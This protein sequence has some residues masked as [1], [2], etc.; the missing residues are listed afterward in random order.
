MFPAVVFLLSLLCEELSV[1][2]IP[3]EVLH[4]GVAHHRRHVDVNHGVQ[5]LGLIAR[6]PMSR[7]SCLPANSI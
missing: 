1:L 3:T 4:T 5:Y 6:A 2:P 7:R